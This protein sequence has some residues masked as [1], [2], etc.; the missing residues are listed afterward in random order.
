MSETTLNRVRA[1]LIGIA[2]VLLLIGFL[3]LPYVSDWTDE[4][5]IADKVADDSTRWAWANIILA[6]SL[7]LMLASAVIIRMHLGETAG[8]QRW[9]PLALLLLLVGGALFLLASAD[10]GAVYAAGAGQDLEAYTRSSQDWLALRMVASVIFGLGWLSLAMA[11]YK[12][13]VLPKQQTWASVAG[14]VVLTVMLFVPMGWALYVAGVAAV[15]ALWPMAY[16]LWA[17]SSEGM[18]MSRPAHA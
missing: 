1:V 2:P 13:R 16:L 6:T 4:A 8:E 9:G 15:V 12:S 17:P 3:Y 5:K 14:F 10:L 7:G 18:M 11:I